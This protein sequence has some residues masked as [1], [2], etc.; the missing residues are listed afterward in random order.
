MNRQVTNKDFL[1]LEGKKRNGL[2]MD[3]IMTILCYVA[4]ITI[5]I[6]PCIMIIEKHADHCCV[7]HIF[8]NGSRCIFCLAAG[9]K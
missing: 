7:R 8:R 2:S 9:T 3:K 1:M 5:V 4:L 6:L